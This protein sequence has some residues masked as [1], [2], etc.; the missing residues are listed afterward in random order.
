MI[1]GGDDRGKNEERAKSI[2]HRDIY[3]ITLTHTHTQHNIYHLH[4]IC[5]QKKIH[6]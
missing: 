3:I 4:I 5:I 1:E 2:E 6:L